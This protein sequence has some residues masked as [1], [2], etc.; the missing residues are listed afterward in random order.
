[1]RWCIAG[2][3]LVATACDG[4]PGVAD[5]ATC[6]GQPDGAPC[7]E[8]QVCFAGSC[9]ESRCGDG[10]LDVRTEG[11][12]DRNDVASDG[13]EPTCEVTCANDAACDDG[14]ACNGVETCGL[15]GCRT[16]TPPSDGT[17]CGD[18]GGARI[19]LEGACTL[20]EC[21]DA[22]V[23]AN[24][25]EDCEDAN[26]ASGDGCEPETCRFT[27]AENTDCDDE[28]VC[29]GAEVCQAD[30]T[31]SDP[32]DMDCDDGNPCTADACDA[33]AGCQHVLI[34]GDG[35]GVSAGECTAVA[36]PGGDCD[37][38]DATIYPGAYDGCGVTVVDNDCDGDED[39]DGAGAWYADCDGD[40]YAIAGAQL[41]S[42]CS[43]PTD[44][45][46]TC[47]SGS[48]T[49]LAPT[50][51]AIR[52]CDD[53][54]ASVHPGAA[55]VVGNDRDEDC[56]GQEKCWRDRDN[57]GHRTDE[58]V[59]SSDTDCSDSGESPT[60]DPFE[61]PVD[62]SGVAMP[63]AARNVCCDQDERVHQG[64]SYQTM[65]TATPQGSQPCASSG[66]AWDFDCNGTTERRYT[67]DVGR[68]FSEHPTSCS[69]SG[70]SSTTGWYLSVPGCGTP[71]Y[72]WVQS[73]VCARVDADT[74]AWDEF[75]SRYQGCR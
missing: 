28:D 43:M 6:D 63:A 19:C 37:D 60:S 71:A 7:G 66:R 58:Q 10:I 11:C 18:E 48:W 20:S 26:A 57:D 13:C 52:D 31:C 32:E 38:T 16:G 61:W 27:C 14:D 53:G 59:N 70:D 8:S 69:M 68:C 36:T 21:G 39:E 54:R 51:T 24:A 40:G 1:M 29:N 47:P 12:D 35:D 49:Q 25:G 75:E 23:N 17:S 45:P 9:V 30:H 22:F 4:G 3:V 55:E 72:L 41:R 65:V 67:A 62:A 46:S 44:A 50:G 42:V 56:D 33:L 73:G 2:I 34:D 15:M 64:A 74:C 5:A